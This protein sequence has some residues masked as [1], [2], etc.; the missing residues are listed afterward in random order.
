MRPS[1]LRLPDSTAATTRSLL[2]DRRGDRRVE[3]AGVADAGRA[4]VAGEREAEL[5]ERRHQAGRLEVVGDGPRARRERGLDRRLDAQ[6]ARHG[7]SGEQA[8]PD[9]HGRVGGVGARR[10][11]RDRHRAGRGSSPDR[12]ATSTSTGR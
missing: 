2:L 6:A 9:H 4:A 8:R 3:R 12:P 11:G 1:K 5:L 10:D 7:V